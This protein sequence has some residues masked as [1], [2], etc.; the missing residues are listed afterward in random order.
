M[1]KYTLIEFILDEGIRNEINFRYYISA[2]IYALF[3]RGTCELQ[4]N[5][6]GEYKS[7]WI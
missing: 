2:L 3:S 5:K 4:N 1:K 6:T 7:Y